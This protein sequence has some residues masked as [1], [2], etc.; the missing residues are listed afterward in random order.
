MCLLFA[1]GDIWNIFSHRVIQST[2]P[3]CQVVSFLGGQ[4]QYEEV[5]KEEEGGSDP[6]ETIT[7]ENSSKDTSGAT[8]TAGKLRVK[9]R[10]FPRKSSKGAVEEIEDE[11]FTMPFVD[12]Y[13]QSAWRQ[14][15]V[16]EKLTA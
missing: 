6:L 5:V 16:L 8:T 13:C 2:I 10:N 9:K 14:H 7:E 11:N 12:S 3:N 1:L 4:D 15:I